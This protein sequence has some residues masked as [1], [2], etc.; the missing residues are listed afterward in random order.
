MWTV[1]LDGT[2]V[3]HL[4]PA[5]AAG[6]QGV[7]VN[8]QVVTARGI[9]YEATG[10][11]PDGKPVTWFGL[12]NPEAHSF[13]EGRLPIDGYAHT[14]NDPA[15][16]FAFVE[17]AGATHDILTVHPARTPGGPLGVQLLR[18]LSSPAHD[19]QRNH[20]HPFLSPDRRTLYFTDWSAE[21]HSQI[22]SMDVS[23]LVAATDAVP[24][25]F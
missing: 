18:R 23:D 5:D 9:A 1:N 22:C 6:A 24:L 13:S 4:R 8:H 12:Y 15:G 16:R 2:G 20:G 21:G 25:A 7:A 11:G 3:R 17:N 14:G 19:D 10:Q